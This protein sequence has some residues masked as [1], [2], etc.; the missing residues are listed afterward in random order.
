[1]VAT[2]AESSPTSQISARESGVLTLGTTRREEGGGIQRLPVPE[3]MSD[4]GNRAHQADIDRRDELLRAFYYH[5]YRAVLASESQSKI[6]EFRQLLIALMG[7][8]G[9]EL[10]TTAI[11][12]DPEITSAKVIDVA[13]QKANAAYKHHLESNE[14]PVD[15]RILAIIQEF[16]FTRMI[17]EGLFESVKQYMPKGV[18]FVGAD[19]NFWTYQEGG[20]WQ[21]Q[22]KLERMGRELSEQEFLEFAE[23]L[24]QY[25][26]HPPS[27]EVR[28]L[29]DIGVVVLN[30]GL[31]EFHDQI[32]VIAE[33]IDEWLFWQYIAEARDNG[34]LYSA[35]PHFALI[36]CLIAQDK[37]KSLA[38][39]SVEEQ[40]RGL[41]LERKRLRPGKAELQLIQ[42]SIKGNRPPRIPD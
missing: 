12:R 17:D 23:K 13:G 18:A 20:V 27:K 28:V 19:V 6:H 32:E 37:I 5:L 24:K 4:T 22:H 38:T 31:H 34:L 33:P 7:D 29:W 2:R 42:S 9:A 10:L 15:P 16:E 36:E 35:N 1:M 11:M 26:C 40:R 14:Q 41:T 25:Y 3:I 8:R 21:Q 30:G 39:L